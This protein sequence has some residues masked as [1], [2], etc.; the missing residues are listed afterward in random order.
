MTS[1][2]V[3]LRALTKA[4]IFSVKALAG[5]V[6][7]P[8]L[9]DRKALVLGVGSKGEGGF[10]GDAT[11]IERVAPL[12]RPPREIGALKAAVLRSRGGGLDGSGCIFILSASRK[13]KEHRRGE[14]KCRDGAKAF[15]PFTVMYHGVP[16]SFQS[17]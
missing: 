2:S 11:V 6:P 5:Q 16:V 10:G 9:V 4:G 1:A 15:S 14:G 12:D 3:S 8:G 17:I 7:V 13:R